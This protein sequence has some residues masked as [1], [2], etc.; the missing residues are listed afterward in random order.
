MGLIT[1]FLCCQVQVR[2]HD[3]VSSYRGSCIG[4]GE[5]SDSQVCTFNYKG[6]VGTRLWNAV[7]HAAGRLLSATGDRSKWLVAL[8]DGAA[9]DKP[10]QV[11]QMLRADGTDIRVLFITVGLENKDKKVISDTCVRNEAGGDKLIPADGGRVA[12]EEAWRTV[13]ASLTVSKQIEA[14]EDLDDETCRRLMHKYTMQ[15]RNLPTGWSDSNLLLRDPPWSMQKQAHWLR[16]LHRRVHVLKESKK[17]NMNERYERFGSITM[18]V[19]LE[20]AEHALSA[21]YRHDWGAAAHEQF[22]YWQEQQFELPTNLHELSL[23]ELKAQCGRLSERADLDD[24][25]IGQLRIIAQE[26]N[27]DSIIQGLKA[28]A[29]D[30]KWSIIATNP[31]AMSD[32]RRAQ[33]QSLDMHVPSINEL[34]KDKVLHSHLA[35]GLGI[36]VEDNV[37]AHPDFDMKLGELEAISNALLSNSP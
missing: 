16:Y 25:L 21:D 22:V 37:E 1:L 20:E 6:A 13:G 34:Y 15:R 14:S 3:Q 31:E 29:T 26:K 27:P 11:H 36:S 28:I 12:L 10:N 17:F 32:E 9:H 18:S 35:A 8:T 4:N 24:L 2:V 7:G 5:R 33:L 19:M 23:P 30:T